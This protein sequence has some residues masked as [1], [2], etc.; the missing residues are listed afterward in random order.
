MAAKVNALLSAIYQLKDNL[1]EMCWVFLI[2]LLQVSELFINRMPIRRAYGGL[3]SCVPVI[4]SA[5]LEYST[6]YK[7]CYR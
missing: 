2:E 1:V 4:N 6:R 3:D 7:L 5:Y